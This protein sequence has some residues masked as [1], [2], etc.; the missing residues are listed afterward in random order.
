MAVNL[1]ADRLP[2]SRCAASGDASDQVRVIAGNAVFTHVV[3][4]PRAQLLK[5]RRWRPR[6]IRREELIYQ[7]FGLLLRIG[8][9]VENKRRDRRI[10][11]EPGDKLIERRWCEISR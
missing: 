2:W 4:D 8:I 6:Q 11:C 7:R 10:G 1:G 9:A 5:I 3:K